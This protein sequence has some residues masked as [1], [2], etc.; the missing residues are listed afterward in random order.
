MAAD[1]IMPLKGIPTISGKDFNEGSEKNRGK[2]V[3]SEKELL[4]REK[5]KVMSN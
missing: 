2:R 3:L 4:K 5:E 1:V